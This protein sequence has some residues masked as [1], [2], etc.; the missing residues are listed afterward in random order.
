MGCDRRRLSR[1]VDVLHEAG[2]EWRTDV[3]EGK[4]ANAVKQDAVKVA[5]PR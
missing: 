2:K 5:E 1:A 3:P 4:E